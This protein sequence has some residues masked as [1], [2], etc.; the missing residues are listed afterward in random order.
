MML[1]QFTSLP[2]SP[3]RIKKVTERKSDIVIA[4]TLCIILLLVQVPIPIH[5]TFA[6][7]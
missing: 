4:K 2:F 3:R 7:K 1:L 6:A 5:I